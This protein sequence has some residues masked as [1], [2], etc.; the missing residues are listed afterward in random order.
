M[1]NSLLRI[2]V[3][4]PEHEDYVEYGEEDFLKID[5]QVCGAKGH[6]QLFVFWFDYY[7]AD[8]IICKDC[9]RE[10]R[11]KIDALRILTEFGID[12]K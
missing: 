9:L 8:I 4:T 2:E 7:Q 5:C 11:M 10:I 12:T 6:K 1:D 3:I